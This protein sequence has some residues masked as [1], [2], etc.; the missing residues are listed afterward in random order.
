MSVD[1]NLV[2]RLAGARPVN[3]QT[4]HGQP[5]TGVSTDT[6][7]IQ[8][9]ELFVALHGDRYDGHDF[10]K[11]AFDSGAAAA[12]VDA[13]WL[14]HTRIDLGNV[15]LVGVP[16]SLKGMQE[17]AREHRRRFDIPI[18]GIA[19]SNGKTSTK[20]LVAS[21]L[22]QKCKTLK[23]EGTLNNHIGVPLTLLRLD[24][25]HK[26]AVIEMGT[27]HPGE[28]ATL[29][30]IA[31]PTFGLITNIMREH[32]EFFGTI[33]NVARAEGELFDWLAQSDGAA[34]VNLDESLIVA[35][36]EK[37]KKRCRYAFT[38]RIVEVHGT[39]NGLG[40]DG[41][42][43]LGVN[44]TARRV[45]FGA[46]VGLVGR[47]HIHNALAAVAVGIFFGVQPQQIVDALFSQQ[48]AKHRM[49]MFQL[50][51]VTIIDD[52]YNANP[53]SMLAALRTLAELPCKGRRIAALGNMGELGEKKADYHREIGAA[54][55]AL[56]IQALFTVGDLGRIIFE[57]ATPKS[58]THCKDREEMTQRLNATIREGDML[59][60]KASRSVKLDLV[61]DAL[62]QG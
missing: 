21:V 48:P 4:L 33:E 57:A 13:N 23:T 17:L 25:T 19:G 43:L 27:N 10:L 28:V 37:V 36:A 14:A 59:L 18:V 22:S 39:D 58:G 41:K 3:W 1:S 2:E 51:G 15:P 42:G 5:F 24:Q 60:L 32:M 7:T 55:R 26:A 62:K 54:V 6:R 30:E 35:A 12:L 40:P 61:V 56:G 49:H 38:S 52:T 47:H 29:C 50:H 45:K 8:S 53:D 31:E 20:E 16:D 34:F 9:G 44:C 46:S 11:T